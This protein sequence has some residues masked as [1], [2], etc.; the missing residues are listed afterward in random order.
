M[1]YSVIQILCF[2]I[3]FLSERLSI[4][5][6]RILNSSTSIV[7]LAVFPFSSVIIC[8]IYYLGSPMLGASIFTIVISS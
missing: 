2:F 6:S 7:L 4:D 1:N 8:I 5:E 3:D